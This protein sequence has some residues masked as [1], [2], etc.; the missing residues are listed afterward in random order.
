VNVNANV[1]MTVIV[2]M[3][4][5]ASGENTRA[6]GLLR[7]RDRAPDRAPGPNRDRAEAARPPTRAPL[8]CAPAYAPVRVRRT[9]GTTMQDTTTQDILTIVCGTTTSRLVAFP[10]D[11]AL[12]LAPFLVETARRTTLRGDPVVP[13]P[14]LSLHQP[15][16]A[17]LASLNSPAVSE[18][19]RIS[20]V[21]RDHSYRTFKCKVFVA[22]VVVGVVPGV[23]LVVLGLEELGLF[24]DMHNLCISDL[25]RP[26]PFY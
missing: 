2:T 23:V 16:L 1:D 15:Q 22:V 8:I 17:L 14:C 24:L 18:N 6:A 12:G 10:L 21:S 4:G 5:V 20:G 13:P 25:V 26:F 9:A 7:I 11:L 3:T 19:S